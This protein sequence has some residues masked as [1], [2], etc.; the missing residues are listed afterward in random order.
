M[1]SITFRILLK[2][3]RTSSSV[4]RLNKN[5]L[6]KKESKNRKLLLYF[7]RNSDNIFYFNLNLKNKT[8]DL[9]HFALHSINSNQQ[10]WEILYYLAYLYSITHLYQ[11]EMVVSMV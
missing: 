2:S 4:L 5:Y 7:L 6:K 9:Q 8:R 11:Q 10:I 1:S 3:I